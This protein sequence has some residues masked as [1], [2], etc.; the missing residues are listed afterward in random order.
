MDE[1]RPNQVRLMMDLCEGGE[2]YDRI[3]Q[4]HF[5]PEPEAKIL[6]RNLLEACTYIHSRGIM[7]RDLKPENVLLV[8]KVSNTDVKISDFGL[9]RMSRDYPHRLPR[10]H[11]ICGS[12]FYLAPEVIK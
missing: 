6:V 11:S 1:S 4:K 12:D 5:Y 10:S 7:H 9:A 8:S 2:L 3:Q